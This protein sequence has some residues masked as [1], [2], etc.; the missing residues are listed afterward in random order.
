MTETNA[1]NGTASEKKDKI[2]TVVEESK[3]LPQM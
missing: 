2:S 1:L 3:E